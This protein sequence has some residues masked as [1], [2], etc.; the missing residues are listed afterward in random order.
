[1]RLRG[2]RFCKI[3]CARMRHTTNMVPVT[4]QVKL[5]SSRSNAMSAP[6]RLPKERYFTAPGSVFYGARPNQPA[7]VRWPLIT[8][9]ARLTLPRRELIFTIAKANRAVSKML[10]FLS[11]VR[12]NLPLPLQTPPSCIPDWSLVIKMHRRSNGIRRVQ[13][14]I[15][16]SLFH[17]LVDF[18][19]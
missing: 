19:A 3:L 12:H 14:L 1:M 16:G 5:A 17:R 15:T 9:T 2:L 7:P 10:H 11:N 13:S 8:S 4:V 18:H 6:N